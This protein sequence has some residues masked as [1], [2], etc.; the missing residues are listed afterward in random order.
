MTWYRFDR[1]GRHCRG[2]H[3]LLRGNRK[4]SDRVPGAQWGNLFDEKPLYL[5]NL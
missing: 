2:D 5:W 1:R 4:A 3:F